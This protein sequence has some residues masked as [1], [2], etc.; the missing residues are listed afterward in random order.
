MPQYAI[1]QSHPANICPMTNKAV[2]DFAMKM[3]GKRKSIAKKLKVKIVM[4]LH[5]DPNHKAFLLLDA[6]T[7]EAARDFL[8]L[9]GYTHYTENEFHL[10]TPIEEMLKQVDQIPTIY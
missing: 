8:V 2:R 1:L 10:V 4:E 3:L 6:P 5:L 7:A 9:A